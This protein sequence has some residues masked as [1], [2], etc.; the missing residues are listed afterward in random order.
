[1]WLP[2]LLGATLIFNV[3]DGIL[4]LIVLA[5][6]A[7]E[8]ANPLMAAAIDASPILFMAAKVGIVSAGVLCLW[9]HRTRQLARAG[10]IAVFLAYAGVIAWHVQSVGVIV[11]FARGVA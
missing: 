3:L 1:V 6:G 10:V 2:A 7:A 11:D 4:T 8:E 5:L 9:W